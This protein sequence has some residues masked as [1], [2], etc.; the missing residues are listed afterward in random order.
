MTKALNPNHPELVIERQVV[1]ED[2]ERE[3]TICARATWT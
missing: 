2:L 3:R 1:I